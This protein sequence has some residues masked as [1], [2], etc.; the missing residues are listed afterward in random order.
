MLWGQSGRPMLGCLL[1]GLRIYVLCLWASLDILLSCPQWF[2]A[3]TSFSVFASSSSLF[4]LFAPQGAENKEA[5]QQRL[6]A[7]LQ[8]LQAMSQ[9]KDVYAT[10]V[11]ELTQ[12][13]HEEAVPSNCTLQPNLL[14]RPSLT[15][16]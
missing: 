4:L 2:P 13:S 12:K 15:L 9:E 14:L 1:A 5:M 11:E 16:Q 10:R 8:E 6:D 3:P 7:A